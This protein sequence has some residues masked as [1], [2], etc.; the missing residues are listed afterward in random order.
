MQR[1]RY[2]VDPY[3]RL[4]ARGSGG[5][6]SLPEFRKVID[7]RFKIDKTNILSYHV[8]APIRDTESVPHQLKIRGRWSLT[9]DHDLL[10]IVEKAG[11]DTFGDEITLQGEILDAD[12]SSLLFAVTTKTDE[13]RQTTYVLTLEGFWKADNFNRLSFHARREKGRYDILTFNGA[14][15]IGENY[16]IVYQYEKVALIRKKRE[17]HRLIFKGHWD[18][19]DR[20]RI[21]Y[22]LGRDTASGFDFQTSGGIFKED[23]IEYELGIRK[24]FEATPVKRTVTLFGAWRLKKDTGL[25]FEIEC[26]DKKTQ[27]IIFGA[28]AKLTGKDTISF[29]LKDDTENKDLGVNLELSHDILKGEGE[30][31][32]RLLKSGRESAIYA[33]AAWRW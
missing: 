10:L 5:K 30:A 6:S 18:I 2:E 21:S 31:F 15:E 20:F 29:R 27:T 19:R 32:L 7:G 8:K 3:N 22:S 24:A 9:D 26:A 17:L 23:Y 33:G 25:I 4:V 12:E 11:R 16:Q 14:W 1:I 28:E 13:D